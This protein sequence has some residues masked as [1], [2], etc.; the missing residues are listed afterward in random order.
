MRITRP[1]SRAVSALVLASL[2]V[3]AT[4]AVAATKPKPKSTWVSVT[5]GQGQI[6]S[7]SQSTKLSSDSQ[8]ITVKGK[9]YD[10]TLG[11]LVTVCVVPAP[12]EKP[13]PCGSGVDKLGVT[14]TS[15]WISS[16]PPF[17]GKA[18]ATPYGIGGTFNVRL[19]VTP[20]AGDQDCR[21]VKCGIYTRADMMNVD[22][23]AAD[24]YIPVTFKSAGK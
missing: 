9:R 1:L 10:E 15:R 17:Y 11:I 4:S 2:L 19:K 21:I 16:N 3:P 6:L 22:N 13:T 18:L 8:W 20:M 14:G 7:A 23:R 5:G 12:G 24:L